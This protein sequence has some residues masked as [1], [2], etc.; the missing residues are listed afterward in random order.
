MAPVKRHAYNVNF[1]LKASRNTVEHGNR[2]T[3]ARDFNI[4]V[5]VSCSSRIN[6]T[7]LEEAGR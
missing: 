2:A 5:E 4:I 3:A 6:S 1:K 7:E